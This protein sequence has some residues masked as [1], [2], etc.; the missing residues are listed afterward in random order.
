M[1]G[2][3]Y[4]LGEIPG[5]APQYPARRP[6]Q[7]TEPG[8]PDPFPTQVYGE[9][10]RALRGLANEALARRQQRALDYLARVRAG[11]SAALAQQQLAGGRLQQ[12]QM[13][14]AARGPLTQRAAMYGQARAAD[15]QLGQ[16]ALQR[17]QEQQVAEAMLQQVYGAQAAQRLQQAQLDLQGYGI[18][19]QQAVARQEKAAAEAAAEEQMIQQVV[20]ASLGA[21]AGGMAM[22]DRRLKHDA[23]RPRTAWEQE[24]YQALRGD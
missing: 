8:L 1:N 15:R 23:Q 17:A 6:A 19:R 10:E 12:Q 9:Q 11:Q 20:G 24:L 14:A 22:S 13:A 18:A 5:G 16:A 7:P 3:Q 21:A 4:Q 2:D